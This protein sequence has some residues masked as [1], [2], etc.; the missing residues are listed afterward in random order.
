MK[1]EKEMKELL[2]D[3]LI[4]QYTPK[5]WMQFSENGNVVTSFQIL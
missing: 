1:V 5:N 2:G 3:S 4:A